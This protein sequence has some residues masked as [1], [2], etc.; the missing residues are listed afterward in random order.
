M[1]KTEEEKAGPPAKAATAAIAKKDDDRDFVNRVSDHIQQLTEGGELELPE[2]YS[3]NNALKAAWLSL[4][5]VQDKERR[6]AL[7]VCTKA[8]IA[9]AMLDM[10][11][12]GLSPQRQQCYFIVYGKTLACQRSTHGHEAVFK[13]I[14]GAA[15]EVWAE[16][17]YEGDEVEYRIERGQKMVTKHVQAFEHIHQDKILG[18]YAIAEPE[19]KPARCVI[20]TIE[21]IRRAWEQGQTK[22][23]SPAHTGFPDEMARKTVKWRVLKPILNSADDSTLV[24]AVRRQDA[25]IAEAE[26]EAVVDEEAN[27]TPLALPGAGEDAETVEPQ[28]ATPAATE[29][30][31]PAAA[32]AA[33]KPANEQAKLA[34]PGW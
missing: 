29:E 2:H 16:V 6:P 23:K 3:I 34:G 20:M 4:Q 5:E 1:S 7:E 25:L 11:V 14:C 9:N 31:A 19:G 15:S 30:P 27:A 28:P 24:R 12:Q 8:S 33:A 26:M 22:G 17:I 21:Q 10:A 18:A 32:T 13:R